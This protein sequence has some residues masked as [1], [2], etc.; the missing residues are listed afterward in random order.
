MATRFRPGTDTWV[1]SDS[2]TSS[3]SG[4]FEDDGQTA[5]FY[6][7]DRA[8]ADHAILD[9]VHI[10]NVANVSDRD[11]DSEVEIVWSTDGLKAALLINRYPHAVINFEAQRAYSRSNF[12][13]PPKGSWSD[14]AR[15]PWDDSLL[16]LF[17]TG[18]PQH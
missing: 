12:P 16:N 15:K 14:G 4:V 5:Y 11:R 7:Y 10:Y 17:H 6:A 9:A 8:N 13:P 3:F 2:P 1:A 18:R